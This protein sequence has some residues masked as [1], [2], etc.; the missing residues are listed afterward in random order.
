MSIN[1]EG[2]EKIKKNSKMFYVIMLAVLVVGFTFGS[3]FA[4]TVDIAGWF[5]NDEPE[6]ITGTEGEMSFEEARPQLED[7][8]RQEKEQEIFMGHLEDL[9]ESSDVE[10]NLD[11]MDEGDESE[12]V[13]TANGEEITKEEMLQMKEQ[14]KQQLAMMGMDPES[15]EAN[16]MMIDMRPQI[17]DN[18]I[19]NVLLQEKVEEEGFSAREEEV[20]EQYQQYAEQFGG[21]EMLKQQLEQE[22]MMKEDFKEEISEQLAIQTYAESYI[23]NNLDEDD[24]DFSEEE[25]K[26]M[27]EAQMQQMEQQQMEME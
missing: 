16:Q 11:V 24:L 8:L 19:A 15:E 2:N 9:R 26:E 25:L 18:L 23:E 5:G 14:E 7:Q 13:A 22:G 4:S 1:E 21:E 6:D 3:I 17:L 12:I 27:Y 10:T 20:E